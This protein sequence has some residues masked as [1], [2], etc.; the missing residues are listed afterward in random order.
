MF[1]VQGLYVLGFRVSGFRVYRDH[2]LCPYFCF[3]LLRVK[4]TLGSVWCF[5]VQFFVLLGL[6]GGALDLECR[7]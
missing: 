3:F 1:R 2:V 5:R 6:L 7:S 4:L